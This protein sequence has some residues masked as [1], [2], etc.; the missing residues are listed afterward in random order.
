MMLLARHLLTKLLTQVGASEIITVTSVACSDAAPLPSES[1][2]HFIGI[3]TKIGRRGRTGRR[4]I[5]VGA[6]IRMETKRSAKA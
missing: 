6:A 5:S 1:V 4:R 3:R 2:P